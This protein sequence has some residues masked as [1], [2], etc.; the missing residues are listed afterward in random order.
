MKLGILGAGAEGSGLSA[1]LAS[2]D[3]IEQIALADVDPG[4]LGLARE[5]FAQLEA[6]VALDAT[7]LDAA[8]SDAV[9]G[10]A[11]ELDAVL[12]A[13]MP[14]LNLSV[15]A[16][17]LRGGTH[18]MDLNSG[19]F[20]VAGMIPY[21]DTIDAQFELD[22][23]FAAAGLTAVSCAG[24]A[25]GWVDLAARRAVEGMAAVESIT[26]RWVERND[27]SELIS[28]TGPDLIANFNMPTPK[29]W[30]DGEV[31][32]VDLLDGEEVY[33]WPELGPITV[34]T[35]F[36]H[37][38]MRTMHN[39]GVDPKR[40]EVKSGLS[41]G[42][43]RSSRDIWIEAMRCQL[44]A[45]EPLG[46]ATLAS[47]LGRSFI[48]PE[49][50]EEALAEGIVSEGAFAVCVEVA[51]SRDGRPVVH[52]QGLTVS[53]SEARAAIPWGTHMVYATSGTT[54][55]VLLPML[56]AGAISKHGVVGVGAL[57]EWRRIL[58]LVE[59]RGLRTWEKVEGES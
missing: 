37:P 14:H 19:P 4:R 12:N 10:W 38:E 24:V 51:G 6:G 28:T 18:Y 29:R 45:D 53:L 44:A 54:P 50:Y 15:M 27:G 40:I 21:S 49:R 1:L 35:G 33:E 32:E 58:E 48:P 42:R 31:V 16:G 52:T 20:E 8:D 39:L 5:R 46:D 57:P 55:V 34:F 25:P 30:E 13:T 11:A 59:A 17:C 23:E 3:G 41:N 43:W 36:M 47:V 56:G 26:V 9:A 22:D 7:L 2:E